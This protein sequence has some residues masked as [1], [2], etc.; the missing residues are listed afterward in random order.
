MIPTHLLKSQLPFLLINF[1]HLLKKL[2]LFFSPDLFLIASQN[3]PSPHIFQSVPFLKMSRMEKRQGC[4]LQWKLSDSNF[5]SFFLLHFSN[6]LLLR[7]WSDI[8]TQFWTWKL[9]INGGVTEELWLGLEGTFKDHPVPVPCCGR[10][11]YRVMQSSERSLPD[12]QDHGA[13]NL[14]WHTQRESCFS[15]ILSLYHSMF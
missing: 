4:F 3:A 10:D 9:C 1:D 7:V 13:N 14:C 15:L 2:R 8:F 5:F 11:V 6:K 12:T